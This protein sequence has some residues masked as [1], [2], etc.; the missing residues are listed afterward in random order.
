MSGNKIG[1]F[2]SGLLVH[3]PSAAE[4]RFAKERPDATCVAVAKR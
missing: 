4:A 3:G 1:N 2:L